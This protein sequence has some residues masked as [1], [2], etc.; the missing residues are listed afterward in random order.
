[1]RIVKDI[2]NR[3]GFVSFSVAPDTK[4]IEALRLMSQHNIGSVIVM[5]QGE[6][7]GLLTERDYARKIILEGKASADTSV[8][9]IMTTDLPSISLQHKIDECMQIMIKKNIRYL[10]VFEDNQFRGIISM[11]DVIT[12]TIEMQKETINQLQ[13][14]I[15]SA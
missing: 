4:V 14:Y 11:Y 6:F 12:E 13:N 3:K 9:D 1:M 15:H 7:K 5:K 8:Q 2:F 10:P